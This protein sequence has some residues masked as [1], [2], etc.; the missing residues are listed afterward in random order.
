MWAG[1]PQQ[2]VQAVHEMSYNGVEEGPD[3]AWDPIR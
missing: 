2:D 1:A 3:T